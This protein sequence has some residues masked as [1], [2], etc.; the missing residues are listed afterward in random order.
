M[1][2]PDGVITCRL[3]NQSRVLVQNLDLPRILLKPFPEASKAE[4]SACNNKFHLTA[5]DMPF[6]YIGNNRATVTVTT[7]HQFVVDQFEYR[8]AMNKLAH[9]TLLTVEM[10]FF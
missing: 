8:M 2:Y 5:A 9:V 6:M 3:I 1:F 4:S 7:T 10:F